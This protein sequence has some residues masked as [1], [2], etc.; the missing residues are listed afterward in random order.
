[1]FVQNV[2]QNNKKQNTKQMK[3]ELKKL[4]SHIDD[5]ELDVKNDCKL[6][7][8]IKSNFE[9]NAFSR[10]IKI[11]N[12]FKQQLNISLFVPAKLVDGKW[13]VLE[14]NLIFPA[15]MEGSEMASKH[16]QEYQDALN[17]VVFEGFEVVRNNYDRLKVDFDIESDNND[18]KC[19]GRFR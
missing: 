2:K 18:L 13:V 3:R 6:S 4:S 5:I 17:N 8:H 10:I 9:S 19:H 14:E 12:L 1:M 16:R 11:K 7:P 15:N